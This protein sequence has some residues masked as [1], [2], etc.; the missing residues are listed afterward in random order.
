M[1]GD[2][3]VARTHEEV[4]HLVS[5]VIIGGEEAA[6]ALLPDEGQRLV[7]TTAATTHHQYM[8]RGHFQLWAKIS[9]P[10]DMYAHQAMYL[11]LVCK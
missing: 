3:T 8:A 9:I 6:H 1:P 2:C 10:E 4:W 11:T 7:S 5:D